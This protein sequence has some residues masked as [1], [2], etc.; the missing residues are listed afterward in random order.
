MQVEN[1]THW[2]FKRISFSR[3]PFYW[4]YRCRSTVLRS[5]LSCRWK[6]QRANETSLLIRNLL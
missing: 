5:R 4:D 3:V 6:L 1:P 2:R